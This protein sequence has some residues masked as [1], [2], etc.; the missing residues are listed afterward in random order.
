M[1]SIIFSFLL[2]IGLSFGICSAYAQQPSQPSQQ[3]EKPKQVGGTF[4]NNLEDVAK[5][6]R[7]KTKGSLTGALFNI[8][9]GFAEKIVP[10]ALSVG[11][12]LAIIY[13]LVEVIN[14]MAGRHTP[15]VLVIVDIALPVGFCAYVLKNYADIMMVF[16]GAGGFLDAFRN[17]GGDVTLTIMDMYASILTMVGGAIKD[18]WDAVGIA[19]SPSLSALSAILTS[20]FDLI[21]CVLFAIVIIL[22]CFSGLSEIIGLVLMG[23]F[24]TAV[25][26]AF[27]PLFICGLVTPW[28]REYFSRWLGFI[29]ASA[30][31]S[32]VVGVCV[33]I[34]TEL[35]KSFKFA[36]VSGGIA[37]S[38]AGLLIATVAI[39][40]INSL[41]Q[42]APSIASALVPGSVGA[43]KGSGSA[44]QGAM[45]ALPTK[46]KA[47]GGTAKDVASKA[48]D[49]L[50]KKKDGSG[51][52]NNPGTNQSSP[53]GRG[54]NGGSNA[55]S[56]LKYP[57]LNL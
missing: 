47:I 56:S 17:I 19:F 26:V 42:Q 25:G 54:G 8:G 35:F 49:R 30:V 40:T 44:L 6:M 13:V 10:V 51:N 22:L 20:L 27:G 32:G 15:M 7:A 4:F 29:V 14:M 21:A 39:T 5:E 38:A 41:I 9:M 53:P 2:L 55:Q 50:N 45:S 18:S 23:P 57:T 16:A 43:S 33:A 48:K 31:L 1:R 24:L 37:P 52:E 28:T 11:G 46:A 36:A 12:G 3:A 34:A